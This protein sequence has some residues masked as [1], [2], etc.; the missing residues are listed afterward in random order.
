M[1]RLEPW[2]FG[3]A[4]AVT[5][6]V[7]FTACALAVALFPDGTILLWAGQ[8]R[9][10]ELCHRRNARLLVQLLRSHFLSRLRCKA[11]TIGQ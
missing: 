8:C 10:G 1:N 5:F 6:S 9:C 7:F 4:G 2:Q 11:D 3:F